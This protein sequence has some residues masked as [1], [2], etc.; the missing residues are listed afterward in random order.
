MRLAHLTTRNSYYVCGAI[1][2]LD[3]AHVRRELCE[4]MSQSC[5]SLGVRVVV[6]IQIEALGC[7]VLCYAVCHHMHTY[8][9]FTF[10]W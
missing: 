3:M 1:V 7:A 2:L 5:S 10:H 6:D 4:A 9:L 8:I